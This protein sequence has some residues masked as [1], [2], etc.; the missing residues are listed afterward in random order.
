MLNEL[1][2]LIHS[3]LF[4]HLQLQ[5]LQEFYGLARRTGKCRNLVL[6]SPITLKNFKDFYQV[7]FI[8]ISMIYL[9][10]SHVK[11]T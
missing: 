6:L 1:T 8:T 4:F 5:I 7:V 2:G 3:L 11:S 10:I 9:A